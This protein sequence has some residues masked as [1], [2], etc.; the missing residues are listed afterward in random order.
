MEISPPYASSSR[1]IRA[2]VS[3]YD[4]EP[5][6]EDMVSIRLFQT[7][8]GARARRLQPSSSRLAVQRGLD[9]GEA[10]GRPEPKPDNVDS[11]KR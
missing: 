2:A 7:E 8:K 11:D 1:P 3:E 9:D 4:V 10:H 6:N 5:T